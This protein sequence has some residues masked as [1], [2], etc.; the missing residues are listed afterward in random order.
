MAIP[1]PNY[2]SS[3]RGGSDI[4]DTLQ[5][6]VILSAD[7]FSSS[8]PPTITLNPTNQ[9]GV[10]GSTSTY[11]AAASGTEPI[12]GQWQVLRITV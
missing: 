4:W 8:L 12:T 7:Y 3:I 6:S 9:S 1:Y 2:E 5:A 10:V 11:T